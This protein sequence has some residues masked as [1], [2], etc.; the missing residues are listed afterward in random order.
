MD[1]VTVVG[2]DL[3]K[4]IFHLH[5]ARQDGSVGPRKKLL[6]GQ[7]L[8]FLAK[9]PR[10]VVAME[11]CA[12]AHFWARQIDALG[13]EVR[14]VRRKSRQVAAIALANKMARSL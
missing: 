5:G 6:R 12:T 4:R 13:H 11:V 14:S 10:C 1:E 3:A 2:L 8:P 7:L 9:V